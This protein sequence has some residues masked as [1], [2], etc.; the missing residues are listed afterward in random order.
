MNVC[1]YTPSPVIVVT[2]KVHLANWRDQA[3]LW[4]I[5]PPRW[6]VLAIVFTLFFVRGFFLYDPDFGWHLAA[7]EYIRASGIPEHDIFTYTARSFPWIDHEWLTDVLTSYV[8]QV[9]YWLVAALHALAWTAAFMIA[10]WK[11]KYRSALVLAAVIALP[12]AGVRA[13]TVSV[14]FSALLILIVRLRRW[15]WLMIGLMLVWANMHGSFVLGFAYIGLETLRLHWKRPLRW[16]ALLAAVAVTFINPYGWHMYEE[17]IRTMTDSSLHLQVSEWQP[18]QVDAL[19]GTYAGFWGALILFAGFKWKRLLHLDVLLFAMSLMSGRHIPLFIV[20]SL[21]ELSKLKLP[22]TF[23]FAPLWRERGIRIG[24]TLLASVLVGGLVYS[25][26]RYVSLPPTPAAPYAP[27]QVAYLAEHPCPGRVFNHYN[28]GGYM[29]WQLPDVPVYIDGRMPSWTNE[30]GVK[31]MDTYLSVS[32]DATIRDVEFARYDVR[33]VLWYRDEDLSTA[34]IE[35]GWQVMP[36]SDET[37]VLLE[38]P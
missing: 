6:A 38:K 8:Y 30:D 9:G 3:L 7:G 35:K 19:F 22:Y 25:V 20:F 24:L 12:Y 34:L 21:Y 10:G 31:Y 27:E 16:A 4:I 37:F 15:Y 29:I 11:L 14:L 23:S 26:G 2:M 13:I 36:S 1:T 28:F 33:C 5:R 32:D 18:W 17:I